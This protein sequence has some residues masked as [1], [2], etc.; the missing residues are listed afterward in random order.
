MNYLTINPVYEEWFL[1]CNCQCQAAEPTCMNVYTCVS[2][3]CDWG[4][5]SSVY[6]VW[7]ASVRFLGDSSHAFAHRPVSILVSFPSLVVWL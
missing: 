6:P 2:E 3:Q 1:L 5:C 7:P 4:L